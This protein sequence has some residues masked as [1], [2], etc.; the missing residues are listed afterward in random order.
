[1]GDTCLQVEGVGQVQL[2]V[3]PGGAV[4]GDL[5]VL[6]REVPAVRRLPALLLGFGGHEPA[7]R[8]GD[9]P[10]DLGGSDP[11]RVG[12]DVVVHEPRRLHRQADRLPG[13]PAGPPRRQLTRDHAAP[14]SSGAGSGA[15]RP[16]RG[17]PCR[18]RSAARPR[19]RTRP[20]RTPTPTAHQRRR[21]RAAGHR[22]ETGVRRHGSTQPGCRSAHSTAA[23]SWSTSAASAARRLSRARSSTAAATVRVVPESMAPFYSNTC[24]NQGMIRTI[25]E[26]FPEVSRRAPG[27]PPQPPEAHEPESWERTHATAAPLPVGALF[28]TT[29]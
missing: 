25:S 1:M 23:C 9:Q 16:H 11:V 22:T 26:E 13:D 19:A 14:R 27:R 20:R 24:S 28:T 4:E 10:V 17:T 12:R 5:G 15:P 8:V 18:S 2:T 21:S 29:T 6:D 3:D 7:D